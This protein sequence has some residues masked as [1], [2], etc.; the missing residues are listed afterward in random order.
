MFKQL[1]IFDLTKKAEKQGRLNVNLLSS[2]EHEILNTIKIK[3]LATEAI[4]DMWGLER[5]DVR[6]A[7]QRIRRLKPG[8]TMI[9]NA[10][11]KYQGKMC[12]GYSV[13]GNDLLFSRWLSSTETLLEN[14]PMLLEQ[15]YQHL[16]SIKDKLERPAENQI[17]AQLTDTKPHDVKYHKY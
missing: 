6:K 5:V 3:P 8:H 14:N 15:C 13:D 11:V 7:I 16:N 4:M 17:K 2:M 12:H 9:M 1:D 10:R